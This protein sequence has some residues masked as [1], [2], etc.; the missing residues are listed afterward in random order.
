MYE[1]VSAWST[2]DK[3]RMELAGAKQ[4]CDDSD[5]VERIKKELEEIKSKIKNTTTLPAAN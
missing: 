3:L 2:L 4:K 1:S 5:K